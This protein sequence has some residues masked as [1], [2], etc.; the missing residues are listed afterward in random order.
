MHA[1]L[2]ALRFAPWP[3]KVR[4]MAVVD[5][6]VKRL[7][8]LEKAQRE[9]NERLGRV[10]RSLGDMQETLGRV[11][12]VLEVHSRQFERMEDALVGIA[13]RVDRLTTAIV[14]DRTQ[15]LARLDDHERR[16][17]VLERRNGR[18]RKR[19]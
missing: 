13:E 2:A 5:L 18:R 7:E 15:D 4:T 14:R 6:T 3:P 11:V 19:S 10:E 12:D 8:R 9:T 16:L 1:A 17:R